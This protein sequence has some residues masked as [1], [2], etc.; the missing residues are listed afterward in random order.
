MADDRLIVALDLKTRSEAERLVDRLGDAVSFYKIGYQLVYGGDG[1]AFGKELIAAGKKVFFDLK[2]FDIEN[3][4]EKAVAAIAGTG[5]TFLTV[6]AYP[7][8]MGAAARA[9]SGSDLRILG[10]TVLT[11][12]DSEDLMNAGYDRDVDSLVGLRAHQAK[13]A[14]IGGVVCSPFEAAL[15]RTL[16]GN[17]MAVVTPGIRPAGANSD[18]QKRT[19]SPAEALEQGA[20]HIVIGRPITAAPDPVRAAR[21]I[22]SEMASAGIGFEAHDHSHGY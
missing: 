9:A 13:L 7:K 5:A 6:H 4:V 18:E 11:S 1:L 10:V 3:T 12:Y 19:L 2:L 15:V 16:I 17:E 14:G 8:V 21:A 22:T 20:S